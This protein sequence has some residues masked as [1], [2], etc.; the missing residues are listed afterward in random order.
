M[1][2][3]ILMDV[4][5]CTGCEKC[6]NACIEENNLNKYRAEF[7]RANAKE[8]LSADKFLSIK[9]IDKERYVRKSCMHCLEPSCVSA[10]LVGG[11]E[12]LETG[13]VIY[14]E[15]KCIGCRYC[16]LSCPFNIPRYEWD[17][18][19][20]YVQKCQMCYDNLRRGELPA[21]VKACPNNAIKFG[22]REE[23]LRIAHQTI[24]NNSS[25][26]INHIWGEKELG[27]TSVIYISDVDLTGES[28]PA[29]A[30]FTIPELTEP[31]IEKT[32]I[33][34]LGVGTA[35]IGLNW[36]IRRRNELS[37]N[38]DSEENPNAK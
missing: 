1:S 14:H 11:L 25:K 3:S 28:W 21:C 29:R 9:Q 5:K 6:V 20:P 22:D 32:P 23:L 19:V 27:G 8:G 15:D 16:M 31:L 38:N 30:G 13:Q 26:Y 24:R 18:P 7:A 17:E 37:G 2:Y 4:T 36:I 33:I 10:C 35:L 34:G 12:K